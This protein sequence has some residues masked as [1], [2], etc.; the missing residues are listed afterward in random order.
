MNNGAGAA[1]GGSMFKA[2]A[3][4]ASAWQEGGEDQFDEHDDTGETDL[5][6]CMLDFPGFINEE[7]NN[8]DDLL[9]NYANESIQNIYNHNVFDAALGFYVEG[10]YEIDLSQVR[11][12]LYYCFSSFLV[13]DASVSVYPSITACLHSLTRS[14]V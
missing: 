3:S 5:F 13:C 14:D 10:G 2:G 12:L 6:I 9:I 1:K 8:L 4:M 7:E 11:V